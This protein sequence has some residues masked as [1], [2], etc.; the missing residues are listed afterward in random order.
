[1]CRF[2]FGDT[3]K[4]NADYFGSETDMVELYDNAIVIKVDEN[5]TY[6]IHVQTTGGRY[7][8]FSEEELDY[9]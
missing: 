2:K 8:V 4:P 5:G 3:V 7:G 6:P 1:M 9:A